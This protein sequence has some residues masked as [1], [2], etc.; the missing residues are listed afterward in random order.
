[1]QYA[2]PQYIHC[3]NCNEPTLPHRVC[4][5]CGFYKGKARLE[6]SANEAQD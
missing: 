4:L 6:E 2:L 1:M 5:S 3:P